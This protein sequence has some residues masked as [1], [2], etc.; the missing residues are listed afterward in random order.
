MAD[1]AKGSKVQRWDKKIH[2]DWLD[3]V[4]GLLAGKLHP[5]GFPS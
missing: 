3:T 5:F 1:K 2:L 4:A